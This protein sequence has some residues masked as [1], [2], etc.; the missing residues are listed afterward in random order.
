MRVRKQLLKL[1][2]VKSPARVMADARN[3]RWAKELLVVDNR[4]TSGDILVFLFVC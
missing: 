4:S 3:A 1:W 2:D